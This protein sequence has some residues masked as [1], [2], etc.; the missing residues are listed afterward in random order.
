MLCGCCG[1]VPKKFLVE[2]EEKALNMFGAVCGTCVHACKCSALTSVCKKE[3]ESGL[4][5]F[6]LNTAGTF[7]PL[8]SNCDMS[9]L[10]G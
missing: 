10:S 6:S 3:P 4:Q 8:H 5:P 9:F 7:K 2:L 1:S